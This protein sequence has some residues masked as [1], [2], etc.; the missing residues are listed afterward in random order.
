[1]WAC[2][3]YLSTCSISTGSFLLFLWCLLT[4]SVTIHNR[5]LAGFLLPDRSLPDTRK[6]NCTVCQNR[7]CANY[8]GLMKNVY[9][10]VQSKL[11]IEKM[12]IKYSNICL[13]LDTHFNNFYFTC[14]LNILNLKVKIFRVRTRSTKDVHVDLFQQIRNKSINLWKKA[15]EENEREALCEPWNTRENT[16]RETQMQREQGERTRQKRQKPWH[17]KSNKNKDTRSKGMEDAVRTKRGGY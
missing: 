11:N 5:T 4:C 16:L 13:Y 2:V 17:S 10:P 3:L 1:M 9:T 15:Q 7:W 12:F 6:L 8:N 14:L